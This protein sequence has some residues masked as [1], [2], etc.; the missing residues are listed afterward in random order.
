[1]KI[2]ASTY[3]SSLGTIVMETDGQM[4]TSLR[5]TEEG[6]ETDSTGNNR[7]AVAIPVI[8]ET[9]QWLDD[10]FAGKPPSG[11]PP[12]KPHGTAFQQRVWQALLN[13]GYGQTKTYA[14]IADIVGC[15]SAQAVGQ[16]VGHNPIA[17]IIPCHRV[18]AANGKLGGYAFGTEKKKQLLE[19]EQQ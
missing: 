13:I 15:K 7:S 2:H 18:V 17:L 16:A 8:T 9:R 12:L 10:Y 11:L 19:I 1:M 14:E 6:L 4:L 3:Y 5:F